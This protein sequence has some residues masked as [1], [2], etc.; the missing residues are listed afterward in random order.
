MVQDLHLYSLVYSNCDVPIAISYLQNIKIDAQKRLE[1]RK[2][3]VS[4]YVS[5][6]VLGLVFETFRNRLYYNSNDDDDL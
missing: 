6:E 5:N 1:L 2:Q 3:A 4:E